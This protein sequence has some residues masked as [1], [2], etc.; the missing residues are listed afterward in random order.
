[1]KTSGTQDRSQVIEALLAFAREASDLILKIYAEDFA[2]EYK[3]KDDPVTLADKQANALLCERIEKTFPGIPIVAEESDPSSFD[4]YRSAPESFFVD[5]IDGTREFVAKNGEFC[6]MLGLAEHGRATA[7]IIHFPALGWSIA[8]AEGVPAFEILASGTRQPVRATRVDDLSEATLLV[9]RSHRPELFQSDK[10]PFG[11]KRMVPCGSSGLKAARVAKGEAD[12][13]A[14]PGHAGKLWDVCAPEAVLRAAGGS[15]TDT[16]GT[17]FDYRREDLRCTGG[18][19]AT[20][21][22][23]H[24]S[25]LRALEESLAARAKAA[26]ASS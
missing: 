12:I 13:Y 9:S 26:A 10:H 16:T 25:I 6:V 7:G 22:A 2:V 4:G 21:G 23:I 5:P 8:G 17:P 19:L 3:G 11:V 1:M 15:L 14:Q 20:N 18:V 24:G